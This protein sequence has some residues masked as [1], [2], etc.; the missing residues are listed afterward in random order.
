MG[1][2]LLCVSVSLLRLLLMANRIIFGPSEHLTFFCI[3][4]EPRGFEISGWFT[5]GEFACTVVTSSFATYKRA[6]DAPSHF[7]YM[8]S[9]RSTGNSILKNGVIKIDLVV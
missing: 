9:T 2:K 8:R 5:Y 4:C 6:T 3:V 7:P 1:Q